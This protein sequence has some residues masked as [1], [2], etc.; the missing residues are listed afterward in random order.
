MSDIIEEKIRKHISSCV[1]KEVDAL[2]VPDIGT[3]L[4][5]KEMSLNIPIHA[6]TYL[7]SMNYEAVD[8]LKKMGAERVILERQVMINEIKEIVE[9]NKKVE[10]EVFVHGPGCSNIN[11]NCYLCFVPN[12]IFQA[13]GEGQVNEAFLPYFDKLDER[14]V[15]MAMAPMCRVKYKI[16]EVGKDSQKEISISPIMDA[17][18][19]CSFCELPDLVEAGVMGIK[20]VGREINDVYQEATTKMYR[21]LLDLIDKGEVE[22]YRRIIKSVIEGQKG[23][24]FPDIQ[25]A[26]EQKRCYY[27]SM[28]H[29]PYKIPYIWKSG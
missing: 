4:T 5:I 8:F 3:L 23:S 10:I 27:S 1:E 25:E 29:A 18:T 13:L 6:S 20:I 11:V 15:R 28:F 26:C 21:E 22:S 7:A 14:R 24:C 17:Y 12:Y 16:Y 9:R 2:I 19:Y